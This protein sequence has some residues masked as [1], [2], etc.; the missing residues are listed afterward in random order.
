MEA[1]KNM[2][3]PLAKVLRDGEI[4]KINSSEIVVG[5]I[6]MLEAGDTVPADMRLISS[7]SLK[8]EEAALTGE[9]VPSEKDTATLDKEDAP[10][11][12]RHNGLRF[13][14]AVAHGRGQGVV[15]LLGRI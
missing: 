5:D 1:L 8:I 3:K 4:V 11:G 2:N 15:W 12:D 10:L 9:S 14:Y 6:V 7:A 13:S